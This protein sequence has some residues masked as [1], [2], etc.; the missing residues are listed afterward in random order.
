MLL[1]TTLCCIT[2]LVLV[3]GSMNP[4]V[5]QEL[6]YHWCWVVW[7]SLAHLIITLVFQNVLPRIHWERLEYWCT[8]GSSPVTFSPVYTFPFKISC[9]WKK[10]RCSR[11][12]QLQRSVAWCHWRPPVHALNMLVPLGAQK[13]FPQPH[14]PLTHQAL[15]T[16]HCLTYTSSVSEKICSVIDQS[17]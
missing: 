13:W 10:E 7:T 5:L 4:G 17:S 8:R 14:K 9:H 12:K 6:K 15:D 11:G 2:F 1:T 16:S 3:L